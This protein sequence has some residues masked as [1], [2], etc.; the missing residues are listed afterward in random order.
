M[1]FNCISGERARTLWWRENQVRVG[2][3]ALEGLLGEGLN[4]GHGFARIL[5]AEGGA[6]LAEL[7]RGEEA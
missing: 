5:R 3:G 2:P 4:D 1:A 6:A 7:F